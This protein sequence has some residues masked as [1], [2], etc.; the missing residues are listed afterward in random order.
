MVAGAAARPYAVTW[1]GAHGVLHGERGVL[2]VHTR[3]ELAIARALRWRDSM[4][5]MYGSG[6][7]WFMWSIVDRRSGEVLRAFV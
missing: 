6:P 3:P 2:S 7:P 5:Q 4:R 1:K